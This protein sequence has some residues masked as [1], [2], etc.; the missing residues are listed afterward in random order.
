MIYILFKL[1]L[2]NCDDCYYN[3]CDRSLSLN[4]DG[5]VLRSIICNWYCEQMSINLKEHV[6]RSYY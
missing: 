2:L 3:C 1:Y 4:I 5:N 6:F